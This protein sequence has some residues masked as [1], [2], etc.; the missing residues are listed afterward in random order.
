MARKNLFEKLASTFNIAQEATR[1]NDIIKNRYFF[2]HN[3]TQKYTLEQYVD[4]YCFSDWKNR[5]H[6]LD[7]DDFLKASSFGKTLSLAKKDPEAFLD[8]IEIGYNLY[9]MANK[10]FLQSDDSW[11]YY[12]A[13]TLFP[14]IADDCLAHFNHKIFY[15]EDLEQAI[16][17]E[18]KPEVTAVV[19]LEEDPDIAFEIIRYN[20]HTLKG[21]IAAK[22][23]ILI[24]LGSQ[25]EPIRPELSDRYKVLAAD[26]FFMLNNLNIRHNNC[27]PGDAKYKPYV[28]TMTDEELE[29]WYD[30]LYQMILLAKLELDHVDRI[31][32]IEA[33]KQKFQT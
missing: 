1:L 25:I 10:V 4:I 22:K 31:P 17:I 9:C 30:E 7:L 14:K 16:V 20:H 19:E 18:D 23:A 15:N 6:F 28:D 26:I 13:Y 11:K 8:F 3:Y 5:H 21:D 32:K 29:D 33:L 24:K 12:D 27:T 2:V